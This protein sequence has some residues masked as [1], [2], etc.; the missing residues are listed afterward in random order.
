MGII[1]IEHESNGKEKGYENR[2]WNCFVFSCSWFLDTHFSAQ[3][4]I[5][6]GW[7]GEENKDLF[8]YHGYGL[9]AL[10]YKTFN[11]KL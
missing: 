9:I 7:L 11:N 2:S 5:W 1:S 8:K 10:N 3:A 6:A 4:K